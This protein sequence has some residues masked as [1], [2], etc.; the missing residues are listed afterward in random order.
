MAKIGELGLVIPG[1]NGIEVRRPTTCEHVLNTKTHSQQILFIH[2]FEAVDATVILTVS[3]DQRMI[4]W[5]RVADE[6]GSTLRPIRTLKGHD[7]APWSFA[8]G[9]TPSQV[10]TYI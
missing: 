1:K 6:V 5:K 3:R 9:T 2:A 4:V 8:V 10:G 7:M